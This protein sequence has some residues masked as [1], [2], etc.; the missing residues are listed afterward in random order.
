MF[1]LHM[2]EILLPMKITNQ[3]FSAENA[4]MIVPINLKM[5]FD[6]SHVWIAEKTTKEIVI[7]DNKRPEINKGENLIN[8]K[9]YAN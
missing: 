1:P 4:I 9:F 5:Y 8:D 2:V 6:W 3:V 7:L